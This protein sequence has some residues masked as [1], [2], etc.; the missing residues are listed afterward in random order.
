MIRRL[1]ILLLIVGCAPK[2]TTTFYIG[3]TEEDFIKENNIDISI[4]EIIGVSK[5]KSGKY[6]KI[7]FND[8]STSAIYGGKVKYKLTPYYFEF[9]G[10]TLAG[11]YGGLYQYSNRKQIDYNKYPNSKPE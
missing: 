10:D 6:V 4:E 1:I 11:V 2:T 9:R 3:M 7:G 5:N 8:D